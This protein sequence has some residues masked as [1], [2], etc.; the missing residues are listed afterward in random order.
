MNNK[1][2]DL[3]IKHSNQYNMYV[4]LLDENSL[5]LEM[6]LGKG[7]WYKLASCSNN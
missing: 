5:S 6:S 4:L 1:I 2:R 7:Y 3:N